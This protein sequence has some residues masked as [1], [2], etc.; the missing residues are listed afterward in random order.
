MR[1]LQIDRRSTGCALAHLSGASRR[2]TICRLVLVQENPI[3]VT[4]C[5]TAAVNPFLFQQE[6]RPGHLPLIRIRHAGRI[7]I[8]K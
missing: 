1:R 7:R 8:G 4:A 6:T 5:D 3:L 2:R